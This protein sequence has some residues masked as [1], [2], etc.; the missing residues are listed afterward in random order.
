MGRQRDISETTKS[1]IVSL[2]NSGKKQQY[3]ANEM[4]VS[5][6]SVSRVLKE[7]KN[8]GQFKNNRS[9]CGRKLSTTVRDERKLKRIVQKNRFKT[10]SY[11]NKCWKE[12]GVDVSKS[13]TLRRLHKLKFESRVPKTKPKMSM[14]Q[15][16]AHLGATRLGK[17]FIQ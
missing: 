13:T 3:I 4:N 6:C 2:F 16:M 17:Y 1:A 11:I 5:Q 8:N 7:Y 12:S 10:V 14:V 15:R 9:Y